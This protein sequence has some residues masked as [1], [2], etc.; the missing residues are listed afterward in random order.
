MLAVQAS[1]AAEREQYCQVYH[2][3]CH[4]DATPPG[5]SWFFCEETPRAGRELFREPGVGECG[6]S[7]LH[8]RRRRRWAF[9]Q[10]TG[11][12]GQAV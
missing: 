5:R 8:F 12:L 1:D 6:Q 3:A 10:A 4:C 9:I 7:R 11:S 2:Q